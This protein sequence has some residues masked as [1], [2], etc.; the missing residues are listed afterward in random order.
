MDASIVIPTFNRREFMIRS[1]NYLEKQDYDKGK[2]EVIIIDDGSTDDTKNAI[3]KY[4]KASKLNI[5][6]FY[7]NHK[8]PAVARNLGLKVMHGK[9]VFFISDDIY[10]L[11]NWLKEH[12]KIHKKIKDIAV[13]G[14]VEWYPKT[15]IN[16]FMKFLVKSG[17]VFDYHKIKDPNNCDAKFFFI[18]NLSL[19]KVW[20]NKNKYNESYKG[21]SCEDI[22]LGCTLEK[23]G[24]RI[25]FNKNAAAYHQHYYDLKNFCKRLYIV[26][27]DWTILAK[28]HP[29]KFN[30][31]Y[32]AL[33]K[34][35]VS[36]FHQ[37]IFFD[38]ELRWKL[39]CGL[40]FYVGVFDGYTNGN[41]LISFIYRILK[42]LCSFSLKY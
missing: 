25:V 18:S 34:L 37:F 28:V 20:L 3:R 19:E 21:A 15:E 1:L 12:M 41:F 32:T 29:D 27:K 13:L 8:G 40:H 16:D 23:Q 26:G 6:Y 5:R 11:R 17:L 24:L 22:E 38:R 9:Y 4:I 7:Q 10:P 35:I 33:L 14:F 42:P 39:K 30:V 31:N 2:F 36:C